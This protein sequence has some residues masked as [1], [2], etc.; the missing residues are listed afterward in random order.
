MSSKIEKLSREIEDL[1]RVFFD[2]SYLYNPYF[3][4]TKLTPEIICRYKTIN[5]R[6][7]DSRYFATFLIKYFLHFLFLLVQMVISLLFY[8]QHFVF[9]RGINT[10]KSIFISH[11]IGKNMEVIPED[12]FFALMPDNLSILGH[13]V[14]VVYTNHN[15]SRYMSRLRKLQRKNSTIGRH[16]IPKFLTPCGNIRFLFFTIKRSVNCITVA[17]SL[18]KTD[19]AKARILFE[20]AIYFFKRGTYTNFLL[21]DKISQLNRLGKP[22]NWFVTFEGQNYEQLLIEELRSKVNVNFFYYQHSPITDAHFGIESFFKS[23]KQNYTIFTTGDYYRSNFKCKVTDAQI[24]IIGSNKAATDDG[25]IVL[26]KTIERATDVLFAPEG[27]LTATLEMIQLI[28]HLVRF[29]LNCNLTL[30]LHPNLPNSIRLKRRIRKFRNLKNFTLS[31]NSLSFDLKNSKVVIYRSSAV[32]LEALRY[33]TIPLFFSKLGEHRLNVLPS[34]FAVLQPV[35]S[36]AEVIKA[37]DVAFRTEYSDGT[38][39]FHRFFEPM[40][41]GVLKSTIQLS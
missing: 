29:K 13:K 32:G 4:V 31:T 30:R 34:E 33:N 16:L 12:Q 38:K 25:L 23:C 11:A 19:P 37:L 28:D 22:S 41:Y 36:P 40:N 27:T 18:Y 6:A 24:L 7:L 1:I 39:H 9:F 26:E 2:N 15:L 14:S 20:A 21:I 17:Q 35:N 8:Y 10:S 5:T 3:R